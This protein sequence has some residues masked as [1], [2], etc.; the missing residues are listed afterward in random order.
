MSLS[1]FWGF[2]LALG[3][4]ATL[5]LAGW[6]IVRQNR[7][8]L[9]C[10]NLQRLI[11]LEHQT[12]QDEL[13]AI[14]DDVACIA[15]T[16]DFAKKSAVSDVACIADTANSAK[17]SVTS[18]GNAV[19]EAIG[20]IETRLDTLQDRIGELD[21]RADDRNRHVESSEISRLRITI[22]RISKSQKLIEERL[23]DEIRFNLERARIADASLKGFANRVEAVSGHLNGLS[24][25]YDEL[26]VAV[27]LLKQAGL[28]LSVT[29]PQA[30]RD[31]VNSKAPLGSTE[32]GSQP[33]VPSAD[34][35]VTQ[36]NVG[37]RSQPIEGD[38]GYTSGQAA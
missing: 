17:K 14:R 23:S 21:N 1:Y 35:T 31:N 5:V 33:G 10:T 12:F 24:Q 8:S 28:S 26:S 29:A 36:S 37:P 7:M 25:A 27:G 6:M 20:R 32:S 30:H 38:V 13:T 22:D 11:A 3:V 19:V 18:I 16:A 4:V 34:G 9:A 2:E 15:D